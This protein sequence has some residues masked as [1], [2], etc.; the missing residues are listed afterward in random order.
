LF[1]SP[2]HV[3]PDEQHRG[4][5]SRHHQIGILNAAGE[6]EKIRILADYCNIDGRFLQQTLQRHQAARNLVSRYGDHPLLETMGNR[7]QND[8]E[9]SMTRSCF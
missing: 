4:P 3:P 1:P 8:P 9:Q 2:F 5:G 7:S 6:V